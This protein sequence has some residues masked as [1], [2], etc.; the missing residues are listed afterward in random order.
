[1]AEVGSTQGNPAVYGSKVSV[2]EDTDVQLVSPDTNIPIYDDWCT[3]GSSDYAPDSSFQ[4]N[5]HFP[6]NNHK[7]DSSSCSGVVGINR[8]NVLNQADTCRPKL[9]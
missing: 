6:K 5:R 8:W 3:D 9:S 7:W 2:G 4:R 1:M